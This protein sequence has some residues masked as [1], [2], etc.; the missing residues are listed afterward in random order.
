M[1]EVAEWPKRIEANSSAV[2]LRHKRQAKKEILEW[3]DCQLRKQISE[4]L[5][6]KFCPSIKAEI[7]SI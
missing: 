1:M 3:L 5:L 6:V 7:W 2:K 4:H